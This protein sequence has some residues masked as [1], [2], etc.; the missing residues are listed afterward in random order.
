VAARSKTWGLRPL[1]CWDCGF[2]SR[3]GH[4]CLCLVFVVCCVGSGLCDVPISSSEESY[5]ICVCLIVCVLE[6]SRG[7]L[8]PCWAVTSHTKMCWGGGKD[9]NRP[10]WDIHHKT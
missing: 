10:V 5:R 3:Q 7:G 4:G 9:I 6:T 2:Q 8:A 1:A